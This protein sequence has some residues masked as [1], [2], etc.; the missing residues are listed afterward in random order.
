MAILCAM[1]VPRKRSPNFG[2]GAGFSVTRIIS[3]LLAALPVLFVNKFINL[4]KEASEH[5]ERNLWYREIE[6]FPGAFS[7]LSKK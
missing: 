4:D 3:L 7:Y 6:A 1:A 5:D 2:D